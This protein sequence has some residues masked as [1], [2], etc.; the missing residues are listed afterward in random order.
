MCWFTNSGYAKPFQDGQELT[1]GRFELKYLKSLQSWAKKTNM[2][3][4]ELKKI[5]ASM[6]PY[7]SSD[8]DGGVDLVF[9]TKREQGP[10]ICYNIS[11]PLMDFDDDQNPFPETHLSSLKSCSACREV[12]YCSHSCQVQDYNYCHKDVCKELR[13]NRKTLKEW[14]AIL[15]QGSDKVFEN[16]VGLFWYILLDDNRVSPREYVRLLG[17]VAQ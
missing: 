9:F 3:L 8:Q 14:E 16:G 15:L 5:M 6:T 1:L 7:N 10:M 2:N 4:H 12:R 17:R 13:I 11:C